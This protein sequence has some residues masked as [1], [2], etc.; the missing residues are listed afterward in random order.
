VSG[1][2]QEELTAQ[3]TVALRAELL[4]RPDIAL[5][6]ITH[7]LAGHFCYSFTGDPLDTA[8]M[9]QPD[10]Y[11]DRNDLPEADG[12]KAAATLRESA[13]KWKELLPDKPAKLLDWLISQP[14]AFILELL[15]FAVAQTINAVQA[16]HDH[17]DCPR[18]RAAH[19]LSQAVALDMANWWSAAAENYF[20]RIKKDQIIAAIEDA[21][22]DTAPE[23]LKS[24]KK[25]ELAAE[26]ESIVKGTRWLP[27]V[28]RG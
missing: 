10:R 8:V 18:L 5:V 24:L 13:Q 21:S 12:S 6:A 11:G 1:S 28:L 14:Q 4:A 23:R 22:G 7:R 26:A 19:A 17:P 9:I 15:A 27:P 25:S 2:L 3:R 20:Q 16:A